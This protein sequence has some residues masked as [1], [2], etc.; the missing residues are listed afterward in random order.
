MNSILAIIEK[1]SDGFYSVYIPEI[2]GLYGTGKTEEEAKENLNEAIEMAVEYVN[3]TGEC[4][5][6]KVLMENHTIEY[7]Y[8]LSSFFQTYNFFD[9][10]AF[11]NKIGI[12][13][14][15]M[16]NYKTGIEKASALQKSKILDGIHSLAN[17]LHSVRF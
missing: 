8:D 12:N 7:T 1:G 2:A 16:H 15:L 11:A 6:Y 9:E 5:D 17:E 14:T 13:A 10:T 4:S 3:E